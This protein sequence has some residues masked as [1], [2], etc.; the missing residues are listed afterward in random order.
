VKTPKQIVG[1]RGEAIA[2]Q[3]LEWNGYEILERNWRYSRSEIDIICKKD[4]VLIFVEVKTRTTTSG[5]APEA[6]VDA[7]KEKLLSKGGIAYMKK[8]GHEWAIRFDVLSVF[9]KDDVN[10]QVVHFKDAFFPG[11]W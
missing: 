7:K 9:L 2:I 8:I 6:S 5:G 4:E 11:E 10:H 3:H 1:D